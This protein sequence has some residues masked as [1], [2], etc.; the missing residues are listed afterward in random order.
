MEKRFLSEIRTVQ[1]RT[2]E[3]YAAVFNNPADIGDFTETIAPGAFRQAL[4]DNK[5]ILALVDHDSARV[6]GRTRS[7]SL[8]L[9][10]DSHG[11]KYTIDVPNTQDGN[12]ILEL[13][14]RGDLGG[15]SFGFTIPEN[16]ETWD[17]KT[18]T[19]TGVELLEISVVSA[20]PAYDG[21]TVNAR[22]KTPRLNALKRY[23]ETV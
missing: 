12:D 2:L 15:M 19:L 23:L 13:A 5:D 3:G 11:L 16:G 22:S 8:K 17:G 6:I 18:R 20:W 9:S 1:G 4:Q 21:T 10:E 14:R 7:G